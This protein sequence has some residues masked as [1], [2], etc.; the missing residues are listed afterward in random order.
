MSKITDQVREELIGNKI[1]KSKCPE[2]GS[3]ELFAVFTT[4]HK[5]DLVSGTSEVASENGTLLSVYCD[6][7]W[8]IE[9]CSKE[10]E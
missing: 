4:I 5:V 10:E 3:R 9:Q 1:T 2:C 6:C 8:D 7:G